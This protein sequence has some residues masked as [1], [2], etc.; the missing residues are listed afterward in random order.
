MAFWTD[1]ATSPKRNFRWKITFDDRI[2][3]WAKTTNTP[4]YEVSEIEHNFMDNKYY[5]PGRVSW[6]EIN[7]TLVD[8]A[9][10]PVDVVQQTLNMLSLSGYNIKNA[11]GVGG[12]ITKDKAVRQGMKQLVIDILDGDGKTIESWTLKNPFIKSAKYGDLD[13]SND[14]LRTVEMQIRYDWAICTVNSGLF[15]PNSLTE[16]GNAA[17]DVVQGVIDSTLDLIG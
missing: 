11:N 4:S 16:A 6:N 15:N 10:N 17:S 12:Y 1:T 9:G 14:E 2:A 3:W 8:P 7:L 5:Y 13:Y